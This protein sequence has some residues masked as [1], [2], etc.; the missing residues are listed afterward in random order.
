[1]FFSESN[2]YFDIRDDQ[3]PIIYDDRYNVSVMGLERLHIFDAKKWR[4]VIQVI[5]SYTY[6]SI[7]YFS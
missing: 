5:L 6:N 4:N 2:L 7:E 3:W 1:M